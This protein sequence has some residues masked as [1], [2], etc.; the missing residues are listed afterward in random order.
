MQ[1]QRVVAVQVFL[2]INMRWKQT[3]RLH[4]ISARAAWNHEI[5]YS[6]MYPPNMTVDWL[7]TDTPENAQYKKDIKYSFNEYGFRSDP[8]YDRSNINILVAGCSMTVGVGVDQDETWPS[9]LKKMM[10]NREGHGVCMWNVATSGASGDY[11]ARTIYNVVDHLKPTAVAVMWPPISR[12]ELPTEFAG[13]VTQ[14][15]IHMQLF[16][17][18]LVDENYLMYVHDRNRIMIEQICQHRNIQFVSNPLTQTSTQQQ[19]RGNPFVA[20]T[21]G[22]DGMH[23][24]PDWHKKVAEYYLNQL[25]LSSSDK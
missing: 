16:P 5:P 24:G 14:G 21:Q 13:K 19:V 22:R 9:Q 17:R 10:Q 8:F 20:D 7:D 15:S 18:N 12:L 1:L 11:V 3:Q 4:E 2:W 6:M 23:P 25:T